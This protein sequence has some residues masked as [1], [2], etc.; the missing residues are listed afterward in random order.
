MEDLSDKNINDST[1]KSDLFKDVRE[2]VSSC[3]QCGTCSSSCFAASVMEHT[4]RHLWRL[5]QLNY[6]EEVLNSKTFVYCASCYYCTLRCPRG[7][8]LTQAM[9]S[10]K[11]LVAKENPKKH[12]TSLAFYKCFTESV[13]RHGR[14]N[15][16]EFMADYFISIKNPLTPLK[17]APLGMK[18]MSK[19]KLSLGNAI[20]G[21]GVLDVLFRKVKELEERI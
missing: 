10:L 4:P 19:G 7:L 15:E 1:M 11:E 2:M 13:R 5:V 14:V 21:K 9:S 20:K 18:L 8:P 12:K 16:V 6:E 3:I 17:F